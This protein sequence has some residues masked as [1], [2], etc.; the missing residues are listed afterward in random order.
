MGATD[1][2]L[3]DFFGVT[4]KT[5]ANWKNNK[6]GFLHSLKEGKLLSDAEIS[7]SLF[8]RAKGYSHLDTDIRVL[9]GK[10]VQT[11]ITKHY[12]PDVTACIFWLKNR[13]IEYWREK[14]EVKVETGTAKEIIIVDATR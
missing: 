7:D 11:P 2:Q 12:P 3:A 5:I 6:E 8:N 13:Q 10:I 14:Q 4:K 1:E 9:N